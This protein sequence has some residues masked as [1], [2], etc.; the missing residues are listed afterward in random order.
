MSNSSA[1]IKGTV[2]LTISALIGK[3]LGMVYRI[4]LQNLA[5][6]EGLYVYQQV[7]PV[8]SLALMLSIYSLPSAF[9]HILTYYK[10]QNA[11]IRFKNVSVVFYLLVTLGFIVALTLYVASPF[12]VNLMGDDR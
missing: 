10:P 1:W 11:Q 5:G 2:I 3:V 8:I 12:L 9:S 6:D 7:Y 4:P